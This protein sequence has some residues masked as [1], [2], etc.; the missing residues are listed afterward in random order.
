MDQFIT[1][2]FLKLEIERQAKIMEQTVTDYEE[3]LTL[4]RREY[5][6]IIRLLKTESDDI[7]TKA[8]LR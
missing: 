8:E 7:R 4:T 2:Q 3:R 6:E 5:E 1:M